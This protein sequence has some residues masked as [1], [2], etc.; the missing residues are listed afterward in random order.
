MKAYYLSELNIEQWEDSTGKIFNFEKFAS[1]KVLD[2]E[3]IDGNF[4]EICRKF[5]NDENCVLLQF[6]ETTKVEVNK[7]NEDN[8][9]IRPYREEIDGFF[10]KI[11]CAIL[12]HI[13]SGLL[14]TSVAGLSIILRGLGSRR[15]IDNVIGP[16]ISNHLLGKSVYY[17][18][19]SFGENKMKWDLWGEELKAIIVDIPGWGRSYFSGQ[20]LYSKK[21]GDTKKIYLRDIVSYGNIRRINVL[22]K[23]IGRTIG[24][25][26][27][28][29]IYSSQ[30]LLGVASFINGIQKRIF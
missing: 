25:N 4:K 30:D 19:F 7:F 2:K 27:N 3:K 20:D 23:S 18:P 29:T 17:S 21:I 6:F 10:V 22:N 28:G 14:I 1:R 12:P 15:Y 24:V 16:L 8:G 26:R 11:S 5:E 13:R 9:Y